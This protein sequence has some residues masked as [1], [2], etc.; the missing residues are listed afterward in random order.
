MANLKY[1]N[2]NSWNSL[3]I[4]RGP[5]GDNA[6]ITINGQTK[7]NAVIYAAEKPGV[8]GQALISHGDGQAPDWAT[9]APVA[10]TGNYQDLKDLPTIPT[11][12]NDLISGSSAAFTSGGAYTAF[13]QKGIPAGGTA[14]QFL[15]KD[16]STDYDTSWGTLAIADNLTTSSSTTPLSAKQGK[17]LN[18]KIRSANLYS[19]SEIVI[20][21]WING[22]PIYRKVITHSKS[23]L[24][25][26]VT[27][28]TGISNM[29]CLVRA[30]GSIKYSGAIWIP[31]S[32]YNT[33]GFNGFHLTGNGANVMYQE[34]TYDA[35]EMYFILEYTKTTD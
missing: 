14:G 34:G 19:T 4:I 8:A 7:E 3:S 28:P 1:K 13:A 25:G 26:G 10:T 6:D 5:K 22:K 27:I 20:G 24:Q 9:I 21:T 16:S 32:F 29:E 11:T 18:E 15:I 31:L 33:G 2:G 12:T 30:S 17:V 23:G 35:S